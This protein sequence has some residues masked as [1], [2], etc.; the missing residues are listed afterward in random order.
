[1]PLLEREPGLQG[2][3]LLEE[4]Q[5]RHGEEFGDVDLRTLQRWIRMW[6]A[7]HGHDKEVF[8]SQANPPGRL[9]RSDFTLCD[10]LKITVGGEHFAHRLYQF[11]LAY[12]GWRHAEL[13]CG[14]ESVALVVQRLAARR[15]LGSFGC[16]DYFI[17]GSSRAV[18]AEPRCRG[19]TPVVG[20]RTTVRRDVSAATCRV[21]RSR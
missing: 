2:R 7:E 19:R 9:A 5:R 3:T 10:E 20:R 1:M 13:V 15:I 6:R 17:G 8:F 14:G 11:A 4:L 12:S 21:R 18:A 16:Y